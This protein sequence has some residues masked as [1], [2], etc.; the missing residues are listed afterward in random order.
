MK[1][2]E[3]NGIVNVM[4]CDTVVARYEVVRHWSEKNVSVKDDL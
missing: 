2:K 4:D 1:Y 3:V